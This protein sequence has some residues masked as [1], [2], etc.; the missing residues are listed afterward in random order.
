[1]LSRRTSGDGVIAAGSSVLPATGPTGPA[2]PMPPGSVTSITPT[3]SAPSTIGTHSRVASALRY[4]RPV[5]YARPARLPSIVIAS[6]S[7][8]DT[9]TAPGCICGTNSCCA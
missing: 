2:S 4:G 3:R 8:A 6:R 9:G 5:V 1:M 7:T